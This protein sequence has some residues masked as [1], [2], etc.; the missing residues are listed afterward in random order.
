ME[1]MRHG[2]TNRSVTD[3]HL[4]MKSFVGPDP[5]VRQAREELALRRLAGLLPVPELV[6]S[7][8][9][10]VT[11]TLAEGVPA[12]E[13]IAAGAADRVLHACGRLLAAVQ[14]VDP[15]R[16]FGGVD[17]GS[18]LVHNDFGPNNVVMDL[19][20]ADA[21]LLCDWEW[22]VPG[23]RTSCTDLAWAEFIV[24]Y[25]H[26]ESVAAL[27]ALF[28]GYGD[29]P[30]WADRHAAMTARAT[31]H[32]DFLRKWQQQQAASTWDQ[33]LATMAAWHETR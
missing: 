32:R 22:V 23:D 19:D 6:A 3:G 20:M 27:D 5:A 31:S 26:P 17:D 24:R 21:R 1:L 25:H 8:A 15:R 14:S 13:A 2:Y 28:D 18:V 33:R 9:G 29:K 11:T 7:V 16:V 30:A 10:T 12:Q 4:V